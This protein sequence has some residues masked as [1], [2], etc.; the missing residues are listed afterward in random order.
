MKKK[1]TNIEN[2]NIEEQNVGNKENQQGEAIKDE[3][4]VTN[5]EEKKEQQKEPVADAH[6]AIEEIKDEEVQKNSLK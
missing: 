1:K 2:A 6:K 5:K 4:N 3:E